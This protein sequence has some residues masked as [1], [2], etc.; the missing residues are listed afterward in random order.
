MFD[1]SRFRPK[2]VLG[3]VNAHK[4]SKCQLS[5][6]NDHDDG[7]ILSKLSGYN[8]AIAMMSLAGLPG[9][10]LTKLNDIPLHHQRKWV[11]R[12]QAVLW[13]IHDQL[14]VSQYCLYLYIL[15]MICISVNMYCIPHFDGLTHWGWDKM[16][17]ISPTTF[18]NLFCEKKKLNEFRLRFQWNLFLSMLRSD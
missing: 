8:H 18:S 4:F 11:I 13:I 17:A 5:E 10:L 1:I 15:T 12:Y 3:P 6:L 7:P 16:A 2:S 14:L 9:T